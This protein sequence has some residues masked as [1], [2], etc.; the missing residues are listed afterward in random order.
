MTNHR[1]VVVT[2][3]GVVTAL[4]ETVDALWDRLL[5]GESGVRTV[6]RFDLT[7]HDVRIGG[8]CADFDP[9]RYLD[10][11]IAKRL[12]RFAQ[13]AV[14]AARDAVMRLTPPSA[15]FRAL[16]PIVDWKP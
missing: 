10:R 9:G 15:P 16:A 11:K 3:M 6:S 12:D 14:V 2:G 1:R 8:E 7:D 13:F 4:G 5:A